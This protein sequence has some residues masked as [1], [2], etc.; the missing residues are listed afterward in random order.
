MTLSVSS[1]HGHTRKRSRDTTL[2]RNAIQAKKEM[3]NAATA[4]NPPKSKLPQWLFRNLKVLCITNGEVN[5]G[6]G[7]WLGWRQTRE[8]EFTTNLVRSGRWAAAAVQARV[9]KTK[10]RESAASN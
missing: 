8:G 9:M 2:R 3:E 10:S 6:R 5:V 7:Y 1:S 4:R